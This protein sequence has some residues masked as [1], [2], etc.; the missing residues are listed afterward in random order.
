[1]PDG[2]PGWAARRPMDT[3]TLENRSLR[4][5][6]R[7]EVKRRTRSTAL[8]GGLIAVVGMPSW[9]VFDHLVAP[10]QAGTFTAIRLLLELPLLAL[11]LSLFTRFGKRHPEL[12]MIAILVLIQGA[13]AY[14][15]SRVSSEYAPYTLGMSL[16]IYASS[17]LL[18]VPWPYTAALIL[19]SW[20]SLAV[21][22][23]TA[24][25]PLDGPALATICF[26]LGTASVVAF[27]GQIHREVSAWRE[28]TSRMQL[29][30]EQAHSRELLQ[31][32]ERLSREDPLTGLANRRC[33][34]ETLA[35]EFER[36]VRH[37]TDLAILLCD[38][39]RHTAVNDRY[40]HPTGDR[41]LQA[42]AEV[43][44]TRVRASD[45][46]ARL[47]GDEFGVLCPDTGEEAATALAEDLRVR[48]SELAPV[49]PDLPAVT[50][51]IG[52][53][54][55]KHPDASPSEITLRADGRLYKAK[56]VRNAVCRDERV[57][58]S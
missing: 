22:I 46:A 8:A 48:L 47:G 21:A 17:F 9:A 27:V 35:K 1:M 33:W 20:A 18:V 49:T 3:D 50:M 38:L 31:Q 43:L 34:D 51:S 44:N 55:R 23:A 36:S 57:S 2:V 30:H 39:D 5:A 10:D 41:V 6:F 29:E 53:A 28:F 52:V 40:G 24:P 4:P 54:H 19:L 14:M 16:A 56:R 12:V 13:I 25:T 37:G 42:A 7:A 15:I 32:L 45:L 58:V 11:W 26:Y